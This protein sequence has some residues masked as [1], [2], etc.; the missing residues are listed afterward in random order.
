L[1]T[2]F[3]LGV[4]FT[5]TAYYLI[6]KV[7]ASD[8][9]FGNKFL[10][11]NLFLAFVPLVFAYF[12]TLSTSVF[13]FVPLLFWLL[14]LPNSFYILTD[15]GHI[16]KLYHFEPEIQRQFLVFDNIQLQNLFTM[17]G[18]KFVTI[19]MAG[20][21]FGITSIIFLYNHHKVSATTENILSLIVCFLSGVGIALGRF[22]RWNSWDI[23][24]DIPG[25]KNDLYEVFTTDTGIIT[26]LLFSVLIFTSL[27]IGRKLA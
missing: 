22:Y 14:F 27:T 24:Y 15:L 20:W 26:I 8:S 18:L 9:Y 21:C 16:L 1:K 23:I 12:V 19:A 10:I 25:I 3:W 17:V 13:Q 2:V 7:P 6:E 4:A 5:L 11:W